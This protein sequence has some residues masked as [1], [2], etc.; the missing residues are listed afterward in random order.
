[1]KRSVAIELVV[2]GAAS[3]LHLLSR[4]DENLA[5]RACEVV[6]LDPATGSYA[7]RS[8]QASCDDA[9]AASRPFNSTRRYGRIADQVYSLDD[10][11]THLGRIEAVPV[12]GP[13][14]LDRLRPYLDGAYASDG[15]AI[16]YGWRRA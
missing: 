12:E 10:F 16:F 11:S 6:L 13:I 14:V 15:K 4:A 1:M 9:V 5:R 8:L 3:C 2:F 7:D